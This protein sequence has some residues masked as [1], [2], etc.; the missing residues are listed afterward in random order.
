MIIV[1]YLIMSWYK[2]K[3]QG[4][5]K[6]NKVQ[7]FERYSFKQKVTTIAYTNTT[8]DSN[9]RVNWK[10]LLVHGFSKN[11]IHMHVTVKDHLYE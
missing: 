11:T 10:L 5:L 3:T 2:F 7:V 6:S 8:I 1:V 4:V 9:N